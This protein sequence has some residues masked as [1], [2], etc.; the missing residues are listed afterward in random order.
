MTRYVTRRL[1]WAIPTVLVVTFLA[2]LTLRAVTDPVASY[3]RLNPR[4]T[5]EKLQ[6]YRQ[7][8]V[9]VPPASAELERVGA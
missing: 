4:A 9:A 8:G 6:Q 7:E 3:H 5:A 1:L 2:F